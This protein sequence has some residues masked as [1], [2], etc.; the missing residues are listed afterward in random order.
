MIE[1]KLG[2]FRVVCLV[3]YPVTWVARSDSKYSVEVVYVS[4][5]YLYCGHFFVCVPWPVER[6]KP[7]LRELV[8]LQQQP[9]FPL[10]YHVH[11][12]S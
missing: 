1:N 6:E 7:S 9:K 4:D 10:I 2:A 3:L 11:F 8:Q 12:S 5:I